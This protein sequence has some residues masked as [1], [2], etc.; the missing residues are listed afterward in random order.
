MSVSPEIEA[1]KIAEWY[2]LLILLIEGVEDE[3][4]AWLT[5]ERAAVGMLAYVANRQAVRR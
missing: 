5:E 4:D 2:K 3:R 1:Q